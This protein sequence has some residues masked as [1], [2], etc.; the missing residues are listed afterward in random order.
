MVLMPC[1][2]RDGRV[3]LKSSTALW[4]CLRRGAALGT[5]P[6]IG[7]GVQVKAHPYLRMERGHPQKMVSQGGPLS[8]Q[9]GQT[10]SRHLWGIVSLGSSGLPETL[11]VCS[12]M[13]GNPQ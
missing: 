13:S 11:A 6:R 1:T 2:W 4:S 9:R 5:V 3:G 12:V 7:G 10:L 8:R